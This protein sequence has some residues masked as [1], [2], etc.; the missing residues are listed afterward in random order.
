MLTHTA[1][2]ARARDRARAYRSVPGESNTTSAAA[3]S[4]V[5]RGVVGGE[6]RDFLAHVPRRGRRCRAARRRPGERPAPRWRRG[7]RAPAPPGP[8]ARP[9][10]R[11]PADRPAAVAPPLPPPNKLT[12]TSAKDGI[13]M[14]KYEVVD[15]D[16]HIL[17]PPDIWT[18]WLSSKYQDKAPHARE[19]PRGRRRL[20]HRGRRRPR[21]DRARRDPGHAVRQVPLVRRH[22]RRG[23]HRLLQR[24]SAVWPT[25]TSTVSTRRSSSRRNAR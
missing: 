2:G 6:R 12:R 23:A 8:T 16:C 22:L 21:S 9:R 10:D 15:A 7:R 3:S 25:W 1:S 17:E 4:C 13:A 11:R 20:A 24:R 18:N 19:G 5:E 14:S